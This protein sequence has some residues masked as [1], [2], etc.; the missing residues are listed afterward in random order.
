[1]PIYEYRCQS[2]GATFEVLQR[3]A[4]EPPVA[5]PTCAGPVE[6]LVS[7]TAFQLKGTGWYVTDYARKSTGSD[8]ATATKPS[9]DG[10][11][12][13]PAPGAD[14][15]P[16]SGASTASSSSEGAGA[17]ATSSTDAKGPATGSSGTSGSTS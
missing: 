5:C 13:A 12:S 9:T 1:M 14:T 7:R 11:S 2:C 8:G 10:K 17:S 4:D 15:A 16:A 6:K 3:L